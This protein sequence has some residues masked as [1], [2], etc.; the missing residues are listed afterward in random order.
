M[1]SDGSGDPVDPSRKY[2]QRLLDRVDVQEQ[3]SPQFLSARAAARG[4]VGILRP[5]ASANLGWTCSRWNCAIGR[6]QCCL[7]L[8]ITQELGSTRK[9]RIRVCL[10]NVHSPIGAMHGLH[11]ITPHHTFFLDGGGCSVS[12]AN[13]WAAAGARSPSLPL[14][15]R[16]QVWSFTLVCIDALQHLFSVVESSRHDSAGSALSLG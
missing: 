15:P 3:S 1:H 14:P 10:S 6:R 9:A 7:R 2:C 12:T 8:V 16:E 5:T 11:D 13:G 4:C